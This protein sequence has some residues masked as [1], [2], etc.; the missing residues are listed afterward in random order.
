MDSGC[1]RHRRL[2]GAWASAEPSHELR[3]GDL[4]AAYQNVDLAQVAKAHRRQPGNLQAD[5]QA[6]SPTAAHPLA[7]PGGSA[8]G[9]SNGLEAGKAILALNVL[10]NNL[11]QPGGVFLTPPLPVHASNSGHPEHLQGDCRPGRRDEVGSG[12][13]AVHSWSQPI[14]E[15]PASLGFAEPWRKFRRSSLLHPSRMKPPRRPITSSPTTPAWNHGVTR[16]SSPAATGRSFR[17]SAGGGAILQHQGHGGCPAGSRAGQSAGVLPRLSLIRMRSNSCRIRSR[18]CS[19]KTG[20]FNAAGSANPSG[21]SGSSMAAGGTPSAG[22]G[23]P[24]A[25]G[26]LDQAIQVASPRSSTEMVSTTCS[27]SC[28][29]FLSDGSGANKPWLQE[30]PDPTTTV[31]WNTWVEI[32]PDTADKLGLEDDDIVKI[33][34]ALWGAGSFRLPLSRH[35]SRYDRHPL[36]AGPHRL[37]ALCPGPRRQ[38]GQPAWNQDQCRR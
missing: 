6:C 16:R 13:G 31:M 4:P 30:T 22:L 18:I 37:R 1:A 19:N 2:G 7:I 34:S 23:T 35:P 5:W 29:P 36:R 17:R 33:T 32:H 15:F 12:Q 11:G 24:A 10:A 28:L 14:F 26:V 3:G 25:P 8:L 27:P 20:Y 38:P 21:R 9:A